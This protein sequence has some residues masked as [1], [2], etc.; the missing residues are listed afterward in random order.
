MINPF[1]QIGEL[2]KMR[3]QAM[4]IQKKL[5]TIETEIEKDGV[6]IKIGG[7]QKIRELHSNGRGDEAILEAVNEAIKKSQEAAAKEI[8]QMQGG[9][10]GLLGGGQ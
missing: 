1:Q 4:Q 5:A 7:D 8:S 10:S 3:E 2:K 6:R 9:L